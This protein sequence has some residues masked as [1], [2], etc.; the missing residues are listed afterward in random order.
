MKELP[1]LEGI[2]R[3]AGESRIQVVAVNIEGLDTYRKIAKKLAD[4]KMLVACDTTREAQRRYGV[5]GIPHMVIIGK[6]GRIVG[7]HRGYGEDGV[8]EVV[9][10]LNRALAQSLP[11]AQPLSGQPAPTAE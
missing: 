4:M 8:D 7:V 5:A 9:D 10:D 11:P 1:I 2:A 3:T 6:D